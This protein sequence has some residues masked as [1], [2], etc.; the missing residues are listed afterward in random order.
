MIHRSV[1]GNWRTR[2]LT[3]NEMNEMYQMKFAVIHFERDTIVK[4]I[5]NDGWLML[6]A[7][8]RRVQKANEQNIK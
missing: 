5:S 6:L 3:Q 7:V 2:R 1:L 8:K 4:S